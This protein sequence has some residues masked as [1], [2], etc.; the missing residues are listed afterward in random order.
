VCTK[1]MKNVCIMHVNEC[2]SDEDSLSD[3][4]CDVLDQPDVVQTSST[5]CFRE[6]SDLVDHH[7]YYIG[8]MVSGVYYAWLPPAVFDHLSVPA[9]EA[10]LSSWLH[11]LDLPD[12]FQ[13]KS[14]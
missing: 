5:V 6:V 11:R 3:M 8:N 13:T 9:G 4:K 14:I 1:Y 7:V 10:T 2:E 12:M